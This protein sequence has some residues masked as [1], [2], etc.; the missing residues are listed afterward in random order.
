MQ[1]GRQQSPET[2]GTNKVSPSPSTNSHQPQRASQ[3]LNDGLFDSGISIPNPPSRQNNSG[4]TSVMSTLPAID[5]V[6][7]PP[8]QSNSDYSSLFNSLPPIQDE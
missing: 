7:L 8:P 4:F 3:L 2:K 1:G 6:P 5:D